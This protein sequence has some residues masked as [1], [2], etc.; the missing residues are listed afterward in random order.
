MYTKHFEHIDK[1]NH[2]LEN[3]GAFLVVEDEGGKVNV[4]TIGWATVGIVWGKPIMTVFVRPVRYTY[5]LI[6]KAKHFTVCVPSAGKLKNELVTCGSS[7]GRVADKFKQC[8]FTPVRG[9]LKD[10]MIIEK[11]KYFY[12]CRIVEKNK[13][14]PETLDA[15]IIE[16]FYPKKD[17]HTVYFGEIKHSY[18]RE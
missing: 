17:F 6:E 18:A 12:E 10:T 5:E 16:K 1:L 14:T 7:S 4:M 3:D 15:G 9:Q 2:A 8:G 11:C 13:V